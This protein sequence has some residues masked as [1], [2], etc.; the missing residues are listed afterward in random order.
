MHQ[1]GG[2][3]EQ[4]EEP[5]CAPVDQ[6]LQVFRAGGYFGVVDEVEVGSQS[7]GGPFEEGP[8]GVKCTHD[9]GGRVLELGHDASDAHEDGSDGEGHWKQV[10]TDQGVSEGLGGSVGI[11]IVVA[12]QTSV[13]GEVGGIVVGQESKELPLKRT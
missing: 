1:D 9:E 4:V 11:G 6:G 2:Q 8:Q 5:H 3:V 10:V 12:L 7:D 13:S